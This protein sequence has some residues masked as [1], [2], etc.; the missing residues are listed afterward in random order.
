MTDYKYAIVGGGMAANAAVEGIRSEDPDGSIAIL[1]AETN[2]PYDRPPLSK[3]LWKGETMVN[4]IVHDLPDGVDLYR[5][6]RV[7][8]INVAD[9]ELVDEQGETI[10]YEKLLLATGGSV[11][12]LPFAED[13][14]ILY[15]RT[16]RDYERLRGLTDQHDRFAVIGGGFIGSE[17]A[18]AL[19]LNGK[20]VTMVFPEEG[21][22]ARIFPP[23]LARELNEYYRE[24]G[25]I[26]RA[27]TGVTGLSGERGELEL[28]T[29]D[30]EPIEA[31][32]VV[33][34]IGIT[35]NT[36]LAE[37]AGLDVDDGIRVNA[38]LQTSA[39][40][41]YAA[42]DAANFEDRLLG[43]RRR[44]EHEDN[45]VSMGEAAG[46][47]MAGAEVEYDHSPMFYS[48]LFD[49]GYEAVG[50]L[51]AELQTFAD[52][53]EE[54]EKGVIYYLED[55]RVRGVLLWNVWDKLDEAR[56]LIGEGKEWDEDGL[57]GRIK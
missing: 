38:A 19:Q 24:K 41:V 30:G 20:D 37:E 10:S 44:V 18:A 56:E 39:Q 40:D 49:R 47:S 35:P 50:K 57:R 43:E 42:G 11:N 1:S 26:V 14:R 17:I 32:A 48:D 52:W 28:E 51:D 23:G 46:R 4:E 29:D 6:R 2:H 9:H 22:C 13:D 34:G 15:Y 31:Q 45:A 25:V 53:Q 12:R 54:Y 5:G 55:N 16:L 27:K 21:I 8:S 33:A 36:E 3:G 7:R